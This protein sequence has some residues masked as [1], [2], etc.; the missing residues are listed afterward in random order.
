MGFVNVFVT[1]FLNVLTQTRGVLFSCL[2]INT[3]TQVETSWVLP[4]WVHATP[5]GAGFQTSALQKTKSNAMWCMTMIKLKSS[6]I[7]QIFESQI[8]HHPVIIEPRYEKTS[9]LHMR[10]ERRRS[11]LR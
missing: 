7:S 10:K 5:Q 3:Y 9:F 6:D 4:C 11:A 1:T 8:K 2:P